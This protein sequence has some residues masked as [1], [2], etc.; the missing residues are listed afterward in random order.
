MSTAMPATV[1]PLWFLDTAV[2]IRVSCLEGRDGLS[3]I[4]SLAAQGDSPPLH[5]HQNEDEIFHVLSGDLLLLID[6]E[7]IRLGEGESALAPAGLAHTYRVES[8]QAR[9]LVVTG[10]GDFERFV[11]QLSRPAD[12]EGLPPKAGPPTAEQGAQLAAVAAAHGIAIVGPP[13]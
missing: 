6:G 2:S 8:P 12:S 7:E 13:L 9:W 10:R 5:V 11:R 1:Q 3:V 4:E